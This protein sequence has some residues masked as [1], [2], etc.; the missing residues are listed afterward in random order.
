MFER[1]HELL[2]AY[3]ADCRYD[4]AR[5]EE[6]LQ[7]TFGE[8]TRMFN[9]L[10]CDTRVAVTTTTARDSLPCLFTNYNGGQR[11]RAAGYSLIRATD[12][13]HDVLIKD[14]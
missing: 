14:A 9:P 1:I 12:P 5:I 13:D 4:S 2:L 3:L 8:R 7:A 10:R 11:P 6:A